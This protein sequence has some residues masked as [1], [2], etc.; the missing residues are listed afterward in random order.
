MARFDFILTRH[1]VGFKRQVMEPLKLH[2]GLELPVGAH[3]EMAIVPI[4]R[5]HTN[6]PEQFDGLRYY[7]KRLQ[8]AE[9]HKHQFATTNP[10]ILHFGHG[11][12]ACPGRFMASNII[13]MVL[14]SL[15]LRYDFKFPEDQSRPKSL[16]AFEYSFPSPMGRVMFLERRTA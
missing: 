14:G 10:Q 2:D 9:A 4:Q 7:K 5:D 6:N 1:P 15:L 11:K 3:I 8:P 13:K 12:Q 16:P